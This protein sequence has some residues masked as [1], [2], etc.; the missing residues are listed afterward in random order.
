[1]YTDP[2]GDGV[3]GTGISAILMCNN[4]EAVNSSD[5]ADEGTLPFP[6]NF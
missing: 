4:A 5:L 6:I 2:D 3:Y 1:M